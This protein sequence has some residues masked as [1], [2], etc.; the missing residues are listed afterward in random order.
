VRMTKS[1]DVFITGATGFVGSAVLRALL[2]AGFSVRALAR[3]LAPCADLAGLEAHFVAGDVCNRASVAAAMSRR[4]APISTRVSTSFISMTWRSA[5]SR[6]FAMAGLVSVI[7]LAVRTWY[8]YACSA[9][10]LK[11]SAGVL[12]VFVCPGIRSWR[13]HPWRKQPRGEWTRARW[14]R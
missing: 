14:Q 1:A 12:P 10:S 5:T 8:S 6:R 3:P 2:K 11:S 9:T 4:S 7:F 13:S